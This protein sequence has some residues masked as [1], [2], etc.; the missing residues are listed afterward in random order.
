MYK[1]VLK[2]LLL[3]IPVLIGATF[4]VF[5][6]MDFAPG[7]PARIILGSGATEQ[8]LELKREELGM[9]DPFLVRYGDFLLGLLQGDL[10][11]SYRNGQP[12]RSAFV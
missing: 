9:N 6:I 8:A 4:L 3:A 1:Y 5:T 2:R 10:G 12:G 7:D 11:T